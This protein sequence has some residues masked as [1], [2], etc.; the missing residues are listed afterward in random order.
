MYWPTYFWKKRRESDTDYERDQ[1]EWEGVSRKGRQMNVCLVRVSWGRGAVWV[2]GPRT[3]RLSQTQSSH[4]VSTSH[5]LL[6]DRAACSWEP[7]SD[8]FLFSQVIKQAANHTWW[9]ICTSP[10]KQAQGQRNQSG[11]PGGV[12]RGPAWNPLIGV[13]ISCF[14][15]SMFSAEAFQLSITI[16][17]NWY[18][19][20]SIRPPAK[21]ACA[22]AVHSNFRG[23]NLIKNQAISKQI[24]YCLLKNKILLFLS[25]GELSL[26]KAY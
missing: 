8:W 14:I 3:L 15:L 9:C 6:T 7:L 19:V 5:V 24:P 2:A 11:H 20:T 12:W 21:N 1:S 26:S 18:E 4:P 23:K 22:W 13:L 10:P 25:L 16:T 17:M